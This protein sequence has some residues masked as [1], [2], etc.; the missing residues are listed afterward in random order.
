MFFLRPWFSLCHYAQAA[1][2]G[3]FVDFTACLIN[4]WTFEVPRKPEISGGLLPWLR[5]ALR[6]AVMYGKM[7]CLQKGP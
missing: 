1:V 5:L 6:K 7:P 3:S 4:L 2:V